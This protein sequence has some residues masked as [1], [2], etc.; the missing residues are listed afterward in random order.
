MIEGTPGDPEQFK[1]NVR[2]SWDKAASGWNKHTADVH[3]W[4]AAPTQVMLEQMQLKPGFRV[5]DIAAGAGDQTFT[6]A[7]HV[8]PT[9][10]VLATDLSASILEFAAANA[11]S[12]GLNN[13]HTQ[14]AD[15]E[16]LGL[17]END[18]DAAVCRMGL[19][20]CPDPGK[21][22]QA[23]HHSLK[24]GARA[25]VLVF[26]QP[27]KNPCVVNLVRIA[28]QYAGLPPSDPYQP[29][30]LF[31]VSKPGHLDQLFTSAGFKKVNTTV[32]SAPFSL[33][34]THAYLEF[35]RSSASPIMQLMS[36]LDEPTRQAAWAEMEEKLS[37]FE[38]A[39]GWLGPNELLLTSGVK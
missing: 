7:R 39:E 25:C 27:E 16:N 21:A 4:L 20:F 36:K 8:G 35:I 3:E 32:L 24:P 17:P 31:S 10:Y 5:L 19:M 22:L 11:R 2:A 14:V 9:G 26:S 1:A 29:G 37:M 23:M 6:L 34:S 33:P 13:I 28:L 12:A 18:F 15:A 30:T 38:T